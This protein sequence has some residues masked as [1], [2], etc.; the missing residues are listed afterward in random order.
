MIHLKFLLDLTHAVD[1]VREAVESSEVVEGSTTEDVSAQSECNLR[2][3]GVGTTISETIEISGAVAT[4]DFTAM[5]ASKAT[6]VEDSGEVEVEDSIEAT[7]AVQ[8]VTIHRLVDMHLPRAAD[9][10]TTAERN[11]KAVAGLKRTA[12]ENQISTKWRRS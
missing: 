8:I 1:L 10:T 2:T 6:E 5:I 9:A 11:E 12:W 7:L 3:A 4:R